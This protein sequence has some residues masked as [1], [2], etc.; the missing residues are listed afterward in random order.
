[1]DF[2]REM[3]LGEMGWGMETADAS[4]DR[5]THAVKDWSAHRHTDTQ[6]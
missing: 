3:G 6:K 4:W 2:G 5:R 1:M